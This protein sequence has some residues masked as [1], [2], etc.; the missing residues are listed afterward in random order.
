[1]TKKKKSLAKPSKKQRMRLAQMEE[2]GDGL[3]GIELGD[4]TPEEYKA[5]VLG[6]SY[7]TEKDIEKKKKLMSHE[8]YHKDYSEWRYYA[9]PFYPLSHNNAY[10]QGFGGKRFMRKEYV[11]YEEGIQ[12]V[13]RLIDA[14]RKLFKLYGDAYQLDITTIVT[15]ASMFYQNGNFRRFDVDGV[16]KLAQDAI[17]K[18]LET[19]DSSLIEVTSRKVAVTNLPWEELR[20]SES[21]VWDLKGGVMLI[22]LRTVP[23]GDASYINDE[24]ERKIKAAMISEDY[25]E[26]TLNLRRGKKEQIK[27]QNKRQIQQ[28]K[29]DKKNPQRY[30]NKKSTKKQEKE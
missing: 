23:R 25:K 1:M 6:D 22:G 14:E 21:P 16:I 7:T 2:A 24:L 12:R 30:K 5:I 10:S 8:V 15:R 27:R 26:P 17:F 4:L 9:V 3:I 29:L 19:D 18:Y 11:E 28:S 20:Y 13:I